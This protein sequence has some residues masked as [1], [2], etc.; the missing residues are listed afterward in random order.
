MNAQEVRAMTLKVLDSNPE[1]IK[2]NNDI[3]IRTKNGYFCT[4]GVFSIT[5]LSGYSF[6]QY[7]TD[8]GFEASWK[9]LEYNDKEMEIFYKL[10]W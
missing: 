1:I 7:Y 2:I 3:K 10:S 5:N 9:Y 8:K 4:S 6:A